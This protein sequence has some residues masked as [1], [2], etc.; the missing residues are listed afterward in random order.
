MS[1]SSIF[2]TIYNRKN[3]NRKD[4]APLYNLLFLGSVFLVGRYYLLS[5]PP[6]LGKCYRILWRLGYFIPFVNLEILTL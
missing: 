1:S 3:E 4:P 5:L 6:F 2:G